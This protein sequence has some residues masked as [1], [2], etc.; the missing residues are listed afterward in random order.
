MFHAS[1]VH[2]LITAYDLLKKLKIVRSKPAVES[3]LLR[4]HSDLY[5]KHLN[6][7]SE[8]DEE[9]MTSNEDEEYGLGYDCPPVP[10]MSEL[11]S[12]LAGGSITAARCLTLGLTQLVLN[13]CGG[14]HHA[15]RHGAEGFCY[16]NDIVLAIEYLK[17][18]FPKVLYIDLDVHHGNGVQDAYNLST[19]VFTLSIHKY[20]PGFYPGTGDGGDIGTLSGKGYSCNMPLHAFYSDDT[21]EYVFEK[22]F[23][24][25]FALFA[26][27]AIVV[28]CGADALAGDPN[29]GAGVTARGYCACVSR[30]LDEKKPTMLLGGG[31]YKHSNTA[32]LWTTLTALVTGVTLDENIPEHSHWLDYG[33]DYMLAIQPMLSRDANKKSYIDDC[34]EKIQR[35]LLIYLTPEKNKSNTVVQRNSRLTEKQEIKPSRKTFSRIQSSSQATEDIQTKKDVYTFTE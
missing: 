9:Y 1:M 33:P 11:V 21:L 2:S 4:F 19:S 6:K 27:D 14:W 7:F 10:K 22:V 28:Q 30:V 13:W 32:R 25:V 8:L 5:I 17:E 26:P 16:V 23:A 29:G 35:N 18:K 31:G 34:I 3:D 24:S 15:N 20:E 12:T